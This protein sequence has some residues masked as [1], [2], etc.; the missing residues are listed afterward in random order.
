MIYNKPKPNADNSAFITS[1]FFCYSRLIWQYAK[2]DKLN[3]TNQLKVITLYLQNIKLWKLQ[4]LK[5]V[6]QE[7]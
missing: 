3:F 4:L 7:D 5:L 2:K 1:E 6:T